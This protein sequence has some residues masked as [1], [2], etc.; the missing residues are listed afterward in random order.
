MRPQTDDACQN[1]V[2]TCDINAKYRNI[3]GTCNNINNPFWGSANIGMRR[4]LPAEY[5]DEVGTPKQ[6]NNLPLA[7]VVSTRFHPDKDFS[8]QQVSIKMFVDMTLKIESLGDPYGDTIW[9]VS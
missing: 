4:Y 8:S 7:R 2:P 5:D 6:A 3:T 1:A 9:T